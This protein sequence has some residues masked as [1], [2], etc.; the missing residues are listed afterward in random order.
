M[1][2]LEDVDPAAQMWVISAQ[3][4]LFQGITPGEGSPVAQI[5]YDRINALIMSVDLTEG[6]SLRMRGRTPVE[7][8]AKNIGDALN[9]M[10]AL[11]KMMLQSNS[12]EVFEIL[13]NDV[14]AGSSGRDVTI[15][16]QL[17]MEDIQT[18]QNFARDAMS[19]GE[20]EGDVGN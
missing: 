7:E 16:A 11:G 12:P 15:K 4:G 2:L 1:G 9:G 17:T 3:E 19:E 6:I 10:L 18:L 5:G 14:K 13:D 20:D 8:D